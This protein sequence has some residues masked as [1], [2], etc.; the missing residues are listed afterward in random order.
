VNIELL[1]RITEAKNILHSIKRR[2]ANHKIKI[3]RFCPILRRNCLLK[4]AIERRI[5]ETKNEEEDVSNYWMTLRK[6]E[7]TGS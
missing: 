1:R 2:K 3:N 5:K 7:D 6:R 4:H